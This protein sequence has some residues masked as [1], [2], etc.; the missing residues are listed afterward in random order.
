MENYFYLKTKL[1]YLHELFRTYLMLVLYFYIKELNGAHFE[2]IR[3]VLINS[4]I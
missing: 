1:F 2:I 3:N 4:S